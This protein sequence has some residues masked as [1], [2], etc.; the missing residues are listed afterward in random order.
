MGTWPYSFGLSYTADAE[1]THKGTIYDRDGNK[2]L[3]GFG[4]LSGDGSKIAML[5]PDRASI[6]NLPNKSIIKEIPIFIHDIFGT[7]EITFAVFSFNG[8]YLVLRNGLSLQVVDLLED[9]RKR[10]SL[11]GAGKLGV[12]FYV[13]SDGKNLLMRDEETPKS[14][15]YYQLY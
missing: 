12:F 14:I 6:L 3:E 8:R 5:S 11:P 13:T 4:I 15:Y 1:N 2:V 10:I 7:G 9:T